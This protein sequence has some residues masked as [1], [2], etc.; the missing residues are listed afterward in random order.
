VHVVNQS[1]KSLLRY[2]LPNGALRI[3]PVQITL[4]VGESKGIDAI[5]K[6][7]CLLVSRISICVR[8]YFNAYRVGKDQTRFSGSFNIYFHVP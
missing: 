1:V 5:L 3:P 8:G 4:G 2:N 6:E 7:E